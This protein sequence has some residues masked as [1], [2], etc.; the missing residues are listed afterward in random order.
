MLQLE[1]RFEQPM[2]AFGDQEPPIR[3]YPLA[4]VLVG[5]PVWHIQGVLPVKEPDGSTY[6]RRTHFIA[7]KAGLAAGILQENPWEDTA[8][9]VIV[10]PAMTASNL[11]EVARCT[12]L[13]ECCDQDD[14]SHRGW[15]CDTDQGSFVDPADSLPNENLLK[16]KILWQV[17]S[18]KGR[19]NLFFNYKAM[20][21]TRH[22][23][24]K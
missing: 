11:P 1:K 2:M 14:P 22:D 23:T 18:T 9:F 10:P 16:G 3:H 12:S 15:G 24:R 17:G 6:R 5:Q 19:P 4:E 13:W 21:S 7:T 8:V 20:E